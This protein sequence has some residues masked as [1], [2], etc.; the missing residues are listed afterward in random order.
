[1]DAIQLLAAYGIAFALMNDKLP[2][3]VVR[4]LRAVPFAEHTLACAFCTGFH[5]GWALA[6]VDV[7]IGLPMDLPAAA[8]AILTK[9][10]ASAA[11]CYTLDTALRLVET[12]VDGREG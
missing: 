2:S 5:A 4:A 1:M 10:F 12:H 9:A 7:V 11:F 8:R 6:L 3:L